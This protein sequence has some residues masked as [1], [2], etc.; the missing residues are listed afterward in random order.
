MEKKGLSF[1]KKQTGLGQINLE[2][3]QLTDDIMQ[4]KNVVNS[5]TGFLE[6]HLYSNYRG[7]MGSKQ[8]YHYCTIYYSYGENKIL[9]IEL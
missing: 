1:K 4:V 7:V 6:G 5:K 2:M 8:N 3:K 9:K